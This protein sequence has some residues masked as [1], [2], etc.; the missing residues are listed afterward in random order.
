MFI[1]LLYA[2]LY[3][4]TR[5]D[6]LPIKR[7][8]VQGHAKLLCCL[9]NQSE[10]RWLAQKYKVTIAPKRIFTLEHATSNASDGIIA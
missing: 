4:E 10:N 5:I 1:F 8:T 6:S 7:I 2:H 3:A 9:K